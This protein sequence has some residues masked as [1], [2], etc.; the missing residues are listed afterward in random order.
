MVIGP[1]GVPPH[2]LAPAMGF[3]RMTRFWGEGTARCGAVRSVVR[4]EAIQ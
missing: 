4:V 1:F 3:P 2:T